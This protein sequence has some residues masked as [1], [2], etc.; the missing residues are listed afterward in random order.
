MKLTILLFILGINVQSVLFSCKHQ[1]DLTSNNSQI[2]IFVCAAL[3]LKTKC[4]FKREKQESA[5]RNPS[6]PTTSDK[7]HI[8]PSAAVA[9]N[10]FPVFAP[11]FSVALSA[12]FLAAAAVAPPPP[13]PS[14]F[15]PTPSKSPF[16]FESSSTSG[17]GRSP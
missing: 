14:F 2:V 17:G 5:E 10:C 4:D 9:L 12:L 1:F 3:Y 13:T 7:V 6:T 11:P 15:L 8:L 16:L